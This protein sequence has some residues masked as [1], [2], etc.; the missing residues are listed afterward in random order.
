MLYTGLGKAL[1]IRHVHKNIIEVSRLLST[2]FV[3][4]YNEDLDLM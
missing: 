2:R 4:I 3:D 1:S